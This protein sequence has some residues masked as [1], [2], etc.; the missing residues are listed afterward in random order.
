MSGWT[1]GRTDG[2]D[3]DLVYSS[4]C[5]FFFLADFVLSELKVWLGRP[6]RLLS[7]SASSSDCSHGGNDPRSLARSLA[8][9]SDGDGGGG[10]GCLKT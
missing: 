9:K 10:T 1:D 3:L 2:R 4:L 7:S 5:N 6:T 8:T